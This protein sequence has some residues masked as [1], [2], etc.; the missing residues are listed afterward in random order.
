ME[1]VD[2]WSEKVKQQLASIGASLEYKQIDENITKQ[3]LNLSK[4]Q[5]NSELS[6]ALSL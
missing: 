6:V 2:N 5:G 4:L 1:I 3:Q